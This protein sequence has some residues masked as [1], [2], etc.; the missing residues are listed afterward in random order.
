VDESLTYVLVPALVIAVGGV[1]G[2]VIDRLI[3][4]R[5][6]ALSARYAWRGGEVTARALAG[7]PALLGLIIGA[8][9]A[10]D[11]LALSE[12]AS[13]YADITLRV[14]A[15]VVITVV[16]TRLAA[17]LTQLYT[18]RDDA[19]VPSSSIFVNIVRI[20]V[21]ALGMIFV[22]NAFG[23]AIGPL[24]AA[25]GVGGLALALALQDT[26]SNLFS[27]LQLIG[28]RQISPGEFIALESGEEGYVEDM[29][30]RF[31]T[32]RQLSNNLVIIPNSILATSRIINYH[33]PVHEMSVLV[34]VG[35]A[36]GSDLELV[37]RVTIETAAEVIERVEGSI[38][39]FE[40]LVRFHTFG[41]AAIQFNTVLR[42]RDVAHQPLLRHEFIK[43]LAARYAVEGIEI[44]YVQRAIPYAWEDPMLPRP[45]GG[46]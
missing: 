25:L 46:A 44:P 36:H 19:V 13:R 17:S 22:L 30:W 12:R 14:A 33:R 26:L 35:V 38:E 10:A 15:I 24:I 9:I 43:A 32:L 2:L 4:R 5:I 29:T 8:W 40:P 39:G 6:K 31:T 28:S 42:V 3:I 41:D 11:G 23:V 16:A 37:E 18:S 7:I 21:W 45:A 34:P 1:A 27:G 20:F